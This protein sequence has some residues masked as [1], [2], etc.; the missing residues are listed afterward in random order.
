M[1]PFWDLEP[2][3]TSESSDWG[4]VSQL[5][6]PGRIGNVRPEWKIPAGKLGKRDGLNWNKTS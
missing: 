4:E 5:R 6:C 3:L 1:L 2:Y